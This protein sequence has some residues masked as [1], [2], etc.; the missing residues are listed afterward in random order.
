MCIKCVS[1]VA[2]VCTRIVCEKESTGATVPSLIWTRSIFQCGSDVYQICFCINLFLYSWNALL[3]HHFSIY[4]FTGVECYWSDM[5]S[6]LDVYKK[7]WICKEFTWKLNELYVLLIRPFV[8][9]DFIL[10]FLHHE[11]TLWIA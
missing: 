8:L 11:C 3:V 9:A 2:P 1:N 10:T 5:I 7:E 4:K 6:R